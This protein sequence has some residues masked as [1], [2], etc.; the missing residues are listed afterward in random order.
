MRALHKHGEDGVIAAFRN[1]AG[2]VFAL[3]LMLCIAASLVF[4]SM[5]AEEAEAGA[6]SG[7]KFC[8]DAG[9]GGVDSGAIGPTGLTEKEVNLQ[10]AYN[11][12]GLLESEGAEVLMTRTD[13]SSVSITQRWQMANSWDADRFIS[14][15]H[16]GEGDPSINYTVTLV[17]VSASQDS[18]ELANSVQAELVGEFGLGNSG[19]WQV[20]YCGVLNNTSMPAILTEASFM[21]NPEQEQRLRDPSY[22]DREAMAIMRGIHMPSSINFVRPQENRVSWGPVDVELQMLGE[23]NIGKV[24]LLMNGSVHQSR[25]SKPFSFQVDTT[26]FDDGTYTLQAIA[27]YKT[28]GCSSITRDLIVAN[29]AKQWYFAEGTTREG[30]QEWLTILN[31]NLEAVDFT[32]TYA[33]PGSEAVKKDYRVEEESRLSIEV[34]CEVGMDRDVSVS[35]E[36]PLPIMV[37]RPMYFLYGERWAGGHVSGGINQPSTTWYFAEGYTGPGFEEWLCLLNP[38]QQPATVKIAYLSQGGLLAEEE[39]VVLPSRRDTVFVNDVVG[40]DK[41]ISI[42]VTSDQPVVAERPIYF[43]YHDVW[44]GGHVSTGAN[45]PSTTW[46]FAEGFTGEGFEEWLCL[47][48]PNPEPNLVHITYQTLE[49]ANISDEELLPPLSRRTVDVNTRAGENLQLSIMV[50]GDKPLV[51]ER[52]IYHDY[53]GWCQGGDVGIGVSETSRHWYFAEGY[54]GEGFEDWLCL[55]NP[56]DQPVVAEIRF[57]LESGEVLWED[58]ALNPRSRTTI[59]ANYM[60]P[61]QEGMG[62]WYMLPAIS[63]LKDLFISSTAGPGP[64]GMCRPV[65][66]RGWNVE[67]GSSPRGH[68]RYPPLPQARAGADPQSPGGSRHDPACRGYPGDGGSRGAGEYSPGYGGSGQYGPGRC[69]GGIARETRDRSG[70]SAHRP[71]PWL[72]R[73][74]KD[75]RPRAR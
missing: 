7:W 13:D 9:H 70:G 20:S 19:I 40:P 27:W 49:G 66:P 58:I 30:F 23:D 37:E 61:Y 59:Y 28:G 18:L 44:A 8:V 51:A 6:L 71:H 11:L 1:A 12:K 56:G 15:H 75:N 38:G 65:T 47:L 72:R 34:A 4:I 41:E 64:E 36:S 62:F 22:L 60:S 48:N 54:T 21:T 52:P 32:V 57:H 5:P 39:R 73:P 46:Y 35:I 26:G 17:S 43:L 50:N 53:H 14:I 55:Q 24:D 42:Q 25:S 74:R 2:K 31:P 33:F 10:V 16:N 68:I 3:L 69:G 45:Q 63:S 67:R 29:A